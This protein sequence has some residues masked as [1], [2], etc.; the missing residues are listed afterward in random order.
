MFLFCFVFVLFCFVLFYFVLFCFILSCFV[1]F[2]FLFWF[3]LALLLPLFFVQFIFSS[4]YWLTPFFTRMHNFLTNK[5]FSLVADL[6]EDRIVINK[7]SRTAFYFKFLLDSRFVNQDFRFSLFVISS[8]GGVL[9]GGG[10]SG[11]G[12]AS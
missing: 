6:R 8:F 7:Q 5:A 12:C 2:C 11:T 1:L 9:G 3:L 4:K 10:L